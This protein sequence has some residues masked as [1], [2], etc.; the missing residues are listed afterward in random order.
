MAVCKICN[1]KYHS[2]SSC[3]ETWYDGLSACS[4]ECAYKTEGFKKMLEEVK[5]I[6]LTPTQI[7]AITEFL[8]NNTSE[9][10]R[11]VLRKLNE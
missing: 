1:T 2:C 8:E 3:D 4:E 11:E 6:N 5:S 10:F 7:R 9:E